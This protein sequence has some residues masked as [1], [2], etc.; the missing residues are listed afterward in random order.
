MEVREIDSH[1]TF[2]SVF[3]YS[4]HHSVRR[5]PDRLLRIIRISRDITYSVWDCLTDARWALQTNQPNS[6]PGTP[7][8]QSV[9]ACHAAANLISKLV[10][11]DGN[12]AKR[13]LVKDIIVSCSFSEQVRRILYLL[14]STPI[15]SFVRSLQLL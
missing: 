14:T 9:E 2:V 6:F 15:L 12:V 4:T 11:G 8:Y 13:L 3:L 5:S 7:P 10:S 1:D